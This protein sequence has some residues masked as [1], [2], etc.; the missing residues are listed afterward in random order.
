ML[1]SP[2]A[3]F[4]LAAHTQLVQTRHGWMLANPND[5]YLGRALL[6]YGE[7]GELESAVL[8]QL[9]VQPGVV[10][11]VGANIGV[12]TVMLA[13]ET[14]QRRQVLV[15]FEPQPVIFQN[16][17][18]NLAA[19]GITNVL[20]WP[21]ACGSDAS[22]LYFERPDYAAPGNFGSVEMQTK[23]GTDTIPVP[24]VRMDDVLRTHTVG[25]IKIDVEGFELAALQGAQETIARCRPTLYVENDR[26]ERSQALIEWLWSKDYRMWWHLPPLF[27]PGNFFGRAENIYGGL[28][29]CNML[30][31]PRELDLDITGFTEVTDST[32]HAL[33]NLVN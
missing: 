28:L 13:R 6:E 24:C 20:A 19:N 7:C 16:L 12:H 30:A 5:F 21:Y 25:L 15:A 18:A 32:T 1:T 8:R 33:M 4:P 11:E 17:C 10:V 29:S 9:L 2:V 31:L 23:P 27:N 22:T 3:S 14:Q 26:L